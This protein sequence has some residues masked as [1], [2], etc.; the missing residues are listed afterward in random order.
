MFDLDYKLLLSVRYILIFLIS[1]KKN[2]QICALFL[3]MVSNEIDI[4]HSYLMQ[5]NM[6]TKTS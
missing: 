4:L 1:I 5:A 6:D 2:V 3:N